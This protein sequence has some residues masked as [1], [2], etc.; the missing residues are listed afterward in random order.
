[1][2][3]VLFLTYELLFFNG[4]R[5]MKHGRKF[6]FV[7]IYLFKS[8]LHLKFERSVQDFSGVFFKL[9]QNFQNFEFSQKKKVCDT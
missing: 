2:F 4:T 8:I 3:C 1:M 6:H 9:F 5:N 7:G